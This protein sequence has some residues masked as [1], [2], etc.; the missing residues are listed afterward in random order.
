VTPA[1]YPKLFRLP[2]DAGNRS[3]TGLSFSPDEQEVKLISDRILSGTAFSTQTEGR[4]HISPSQT[5]LRIFLDPFS[6]FYSP[7]TCGRK[8]LRIKP[9]AIFVA[10]LL[11]P[12]FILSLSSH[13]LLASLP[14]PLS[15]LFFTRS[16]ANPM[17]PD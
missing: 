8:E 5:C 13:P 17:A 12:F 7:A 6:P 2:S 9:G 10:P 14:P 15:F 11:V 3:T 16:G 4:P 1:S